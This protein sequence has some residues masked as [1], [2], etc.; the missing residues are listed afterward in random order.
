MS[1]DDPDIRPLGLQHY[2]IPQTSFH[3]PRGW[4]SYRH[5]STVPGPETGLQRLKAEKAE[6]HLV[7]FETLGAIVSGATEEHQGGRRDE[8]EAELKRRGRKTSGRGRPRMG[9]V[10]PQSEGAD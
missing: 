7:I 1:R 8:K 10:K 3:L 5:V 2:I 4:F 9:K 6:C